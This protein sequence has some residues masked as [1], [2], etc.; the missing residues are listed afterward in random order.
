MLKE[1]LLGTDMT[2]RLHAQTTRS[3]TGKRERQDC[4]KNSQSTVLQRPRSG[5]ESFGASE[6]RP[7]S[8]MPEI[9]QES[10]NQRRRTAACT[11]SRRPTKESKR[12]SWY[13]TALSKT[14]ESWM[15]CSAM[16]CGQFRSKTS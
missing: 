6:S 8:R 3:I 11:S 13:R 5:E 10:Q 7:P 9:L 16:C 14:A 4:G 2:E 1:K 12:D 15:A